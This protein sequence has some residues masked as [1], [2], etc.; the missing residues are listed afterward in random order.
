MT[1][2]SQGPGGPSDAGGPSGTSGPSAPRQGPGDQR[3]SGQG[4]DSQTSTSSQSGHPD[5]DR[6]GGFTALGEHEVHAWRSFRLVEAEFEAPGGEQFSR[7]FLRH[8]GAAGIVAIDGDEAVLVR[9]YRPVMGREVL[10][11]P[12]GTL[13]RP[14]EAPAACAVR[15]LAEE[16]GAT[17]AHWEHLATYGV[18]VGISD[19][20]LHLYLATELTFGEREADGIEEQTMTV[21]RL[22]L[23]DVP[24]AIADGRLA[25]SKTIIGLLMARDR[26]G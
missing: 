7:T 20:Q 11:I 26:L 5:R 9:Q 24:A 2:V 25:D 18:A 17:A 23:A 22:A 16:A 14:G 15:E 3:P 13:D 19:E 1:D 12:A 6:T 10:E 8:P 21:E 4:G